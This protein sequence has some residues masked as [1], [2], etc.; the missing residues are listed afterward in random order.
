MLG[1]SDTWPS[2]QPQ[3]GYHGECITLSALTVAGDS[4]SF[5]II[6]LFNL[7]S[8]L[9]ISTPLP[10]YNPSKNSHKTISTLLFISPFTSLHWFL[11]LPMGLYLSLSLSVTILSLSYFLSRPA[12]LHL[13]C[14]VI[15][16]F[17]P[18]R[19]FSGYSRIYWR[20]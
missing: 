19:L 9:P 6:S 11:L 15:S 13:P 20:L 18:L 5:C 17:I 4:S 14:S 3:W 10:L 12:Y 8:A 7:P 16:F 2:C 1:L